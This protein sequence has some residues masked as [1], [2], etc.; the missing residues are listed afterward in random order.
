MRIGMERMVR[1]GHTE[2]R[3]WI[4]GVGLGLGTERVIEKQGSL[5]QEWDEVLS[6]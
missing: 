3:K 5:E 4:K 1:V 2:F 6:S